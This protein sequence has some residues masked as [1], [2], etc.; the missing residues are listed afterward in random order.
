[1]STMDFI[2]DT[3]GDEELLQQDE[4]IGE[5]TENNFGDV[6]DDTLSELVENIK[7]FKNDIESEENKERSIPG[8][9][10]D[11][12]NDELIDKF[13]IHIGW[14]PKIGQ[15]TKAEKLKSLKNKFYFNNID[16][17]TGKLKMQATEVNIEKEMEKSVLKPGFE[18]QITLP[19]Y[20]VSDRRLKAMRKVEQEKTK[21][22]SWF[23]IP[24]PEVTEEVQNDLQILKMRSVLDP[25]RFYKKNDMEVLPKYFQV[26]TVM[27]SAL[28]HHNVRLTKKERKRTIVD[29]LLADAEFNKYNK[30]KYKEIIE[31]K[32]KTTYK[33]YIKD[34]RKKSKALYNKKKR[35][36][37]LKNKKKQS[38]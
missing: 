27:D 22:P 32:R 21:G 20:N 35:D 28:D 2:I 17:N 34:K 29:E 12:K 30:K 7:I 6:D 9:L 25:K 15:Q 11:K 1:M 18:K 8:K 10:N 36:G 16:F 14:G 33:T 38:D 3:V 26:G 19:E 13:F 31:E 4:L 5:L 23:N 24:A 37:K